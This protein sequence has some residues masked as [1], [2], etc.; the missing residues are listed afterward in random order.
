MSRTEKLLRWSPIVV[1]VVFVLANVALKDRS[2]SANE[3]VEVRAEATE[4]CGVICERMAGCALERFGDTPAN[5]ALLPQL[6]S[7]CFS[8]CLT[9]EAKVSNCFQQDQQLDCLA[10]TQCAVQY[11]YSKQ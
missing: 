1:F 9:Q 3:T 4:N 11:L 7:S 6:H 2:A 8:G 5:R 10:L